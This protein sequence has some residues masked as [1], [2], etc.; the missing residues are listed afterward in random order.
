MDIGQVGIWFFLDAMTA[1]ASAEF[2]KQVEKNGYK[3]PLLAGLVQRAVA[4]AL[5]SSPLPLL[6][7]EVKR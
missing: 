5:S 1:P 6:G 7:D 4:L 2:A 3:V